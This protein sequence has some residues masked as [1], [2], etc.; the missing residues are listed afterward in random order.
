MQIPTQLFPAANAVIHRFTNLTFREYLLKLPTDPLAHL[1]HDWQG[2]A[3]PRSTPYS[4]RIQPRVVSSRSLSLSRA[5][6][7]SRRAW[8]Q[9]H[10][11]ILI[12]IPRTIGVG[13]GECTQWHVCFDTHM[14]AARTQSI[15][16]R[17]QIPQTMTKGELTEAHAKQLIPAC[18]FLCTVICFV[19]SNYFAKF[20]F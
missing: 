2:F 8:A 4:C 10:S 6:S 18:E 16:G 12:N 19:L 14:I 9:H 17:S 13:I 7:N 20:V 3:Q 5:F 15:E 1:V 11:Q